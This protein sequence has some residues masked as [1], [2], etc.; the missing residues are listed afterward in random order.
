[1]SAAGRPRRNRHWHRARVLVIATDHVPPGLGAFP[2]HAVGPH[3]HARETVQPGLMLV[4]ME[5]Q[6]VDAG[7]EG[8]IA[9]PLSTPG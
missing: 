3:G 1:M 6:A 4:A 8:P 2:M 5:H 9:L 7:A